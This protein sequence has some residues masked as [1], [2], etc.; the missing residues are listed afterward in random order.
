MEPP[1]KMLQ[2]YIDQYFGHHEHTLKLFIED[3]K[4]IEIPNQSKTSYSFGGSI[5]YCNMH[6]NGQDI[7]DFLV[8]ISSNLTG[9][10]MAFVKQSI[11]GPISN[12]ILIDAVNK[13]SAK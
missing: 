8:N 9:I 12:D 6:I 10:G 13:L 5:H 7:N 2:P 11:P 3:G 4:L 1:K